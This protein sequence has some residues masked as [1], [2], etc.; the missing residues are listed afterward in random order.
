MEDNRSR[1]RL[2]LA[3]MVLQHRLCEISELKK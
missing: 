3:R 1:F 2:V